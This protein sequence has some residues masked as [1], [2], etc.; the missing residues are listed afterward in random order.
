MINLTIV[1]AT[2]LVGSTFLKV[3]EEKSYIKIDNL[4]LFASKKSKGKK[5]V[6]RNKNYVVEELNKKNITNKK[7]DYALFSAG[8]EIS[9][10]FAPI[11]KKQNTVVIDNSSAFRMHKKVPLIVPQVNFDE[12]KPECKIIAN[13]NCSTI[14]CMA[15]LKALDKLFELKE[16]V[17]STY[18][19]VSGSGIKGL[20]D[21]A[22]NKKGLKSQFYPYKI[23]ENVLPH[24]D[25]FLENGFTKEEMKM[26]NETKKILNLKKLKVN[27]TCVR[28]PISYCHSVSV[29]AKFKKEVDINLAKNAL[30]NFKGITLL[31][32]TQKNIYPMPINALGTDSVYVGRVR[33]D[34]SNKKALSFFVVADNIRK[35]AASNA[36]EILEEILKQNK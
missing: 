31:D 23:Y 22:L 14:Q 30:K 8:A 12:I 29:F 36:I 25:K 6:F 4:Y 32:D 17:F 28:I 24:I 15:P 5:I 19:A 10:K 13:P 35:G 2:G 1:G 11:F 26:V 18:Q 20:K 34:L 7:I 16:V 9:K 33:K 3:L 27:A 21:L